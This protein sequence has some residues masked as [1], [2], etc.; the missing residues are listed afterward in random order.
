MLQIRNRFL[1][2]IHQR[3]A[4]TEVFEEAFQKFVRVDWTVREQFT[5]SDLLAVIDHHISTQKN[6]VLTD[7][8]VGLD[9][10]DGEGIIIFP[11]LN[12]DRSRLPA[13]NG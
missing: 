1:S 4:S 10:I 3:L 12:F 11:L 7:R 13:K 5:G 2:R 8:V 9:H 6:W